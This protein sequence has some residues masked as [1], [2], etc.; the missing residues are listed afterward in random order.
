MF[1]QNEKFCWTVVQ[2]SRLSGNVVFTDFR[3]LGEQLMG[4]EKLV[5][6]DR[7]DADAQLDVLA[8]RGSD[9]L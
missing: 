9:R 1:E 7:G 2:F 6:R 4:M 5:R 8:R 3:R